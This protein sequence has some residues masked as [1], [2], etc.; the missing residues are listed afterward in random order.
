MYSVRALSTLVL[1]FQEDRCPHLWVTLGQT[2]GRGK[3][4][5]G[6]IKDL[7]FVLFYL[8]YGLAQH[9]GTYVREVRDIS[10]VKVMVCGRHHLYPHIECFAN[11]Q[12]LSKS[13]QLLF[14]TSH[15]AITLPSKRSYG[16]PVAQSV[17]YPP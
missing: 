17:Q 9:K 12:S 3:T 4:C 2:D 8:Q 7:S 1:V 14:S 10:G 5:A 11:I 6:Q 15:K 16:L 13:F